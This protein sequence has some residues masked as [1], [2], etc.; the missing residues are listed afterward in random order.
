[1]QET[2]SVV[3]IHPKTGKVGLQLR[4]AKVN[5]PNTWAGVGGYVE[6]E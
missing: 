3:F 1:M 5:E 6:A 2:S 4:S